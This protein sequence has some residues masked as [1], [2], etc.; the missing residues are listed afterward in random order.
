MTTN[1][2]ALSFAFTDVIFILTLLFSFI[3]FSSSRIFEW[4]AF[5]PFRVVFLREYWRL[6]SHALIHQNIFHLFLNAFILLLFG[7]EVEAYYH[8]QSDNG[9]LY[10]LLY[11]TAIPVS[12]AFRG[13]KSKTD[14]DYRAVGSSG[15]VSAII[16]SYIAIH[17][18]QV[19]TVELFYPIS[20]PGLWLGVA[21]LLYSLVMFRKGK[22]TIGHDAHL[23]GALWGYLFT[24]AI[25]PSLWPLLL[26]AFF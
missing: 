8:N 11:L 10:P 22:D 4:F 25:F 19:F 20:I 23:F 16:F 21:Y 1:Q 26:E 9:F 17:P 5:I 24:T 13:F 3:G 15:G 18:Q 6:F 12:V 14:K 2:I 7:R